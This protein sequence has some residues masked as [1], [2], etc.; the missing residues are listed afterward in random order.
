MLLALIVGAII[1][2]WIGG[3]TSAGAHA[4]NNTAVCQKVSSAIYE[5]AA[6]AV[7]IYQQSLVG[8]TA[9]HAAVIFTYPNDP[10]E[11]KPQGSK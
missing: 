10:Q 1:P 3:N 2:R 11:G 4:I 5:C 7:D 6:A 8:K 9:W